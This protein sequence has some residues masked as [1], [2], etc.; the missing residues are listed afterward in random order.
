MKFVVIALT[1][2]VVAALRVGRRRRHR[3]TGVHA[4]RTVSSPFSSDVGLIMAREV[5]E[6]F[7]GRILKV[8]TLFILIVVAAAIVIPVLHN[9]KAKPQGVGIV[10]TLSSSLR[11]TVTSSAKSADIAI[12]FVL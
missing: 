11:E 4:A 6:R 10:G 3:R 9:G 8:T 12:H 2:V 1:L 5:R 7:R